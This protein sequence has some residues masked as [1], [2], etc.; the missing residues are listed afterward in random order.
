MTYDIIP[1]LESYLNEIGKVLHSSID[2]QEEVLNDNEDRADNNA[3]ED[4]E[5]E[6]RGRSR[7]RPKPV[8][9]AQAASAM[10]EGE[11]APKD[12]END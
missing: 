11:S 3:E 5:E 9:S 4:K 6:E 8:T 10:T 1:E 2:E 7:K 12:T